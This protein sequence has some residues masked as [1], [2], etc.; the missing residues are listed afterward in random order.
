[1][2]LPEIQI[3]WEK[4]VLGEKLD[5]ALEQVRSE[6]PIRHSSRD[7]KKPIFDNANLEF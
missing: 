3:M 2:P 1:M 7:F 6:M 5:F 4:K